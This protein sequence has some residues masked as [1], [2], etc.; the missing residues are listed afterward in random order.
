MI[1][2][3]ETFAFVYDEVMDTTLY[4]RWLDFS[5]RFL[6]DRKKILELACGTGAL[7]LDF[8]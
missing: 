4:Q 3:Y 6:G 8:A 5:L 7:A 2:A 1:V